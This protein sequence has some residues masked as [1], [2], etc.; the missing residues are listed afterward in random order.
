MV[1]YFDL[2]ST[3]NKKTSKLI[4]QLPMNYPEYPP[5]DFYLDRNLLKNG[6]KP[7]H[8][9][10]EFE[11]KKC[12]KYGYAWYCLHIKKWR[13]NACSMIRGDNLLTVIGAIYESLK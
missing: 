11:G 13:P 10:H 7:D 3:Y 6:Q 4:I 8:Y 1:K 2:P 12:C 5:R 9:Y